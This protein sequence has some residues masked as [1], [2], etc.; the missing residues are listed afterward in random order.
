MLKQMRHLLSGC[1]LYAYRHLLRQKAANALHSEK[2]RRE[3]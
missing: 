2:I 3:T 1:R